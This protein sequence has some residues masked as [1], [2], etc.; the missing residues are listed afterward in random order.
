MANLFNNNILKD[1]LKDFEIP[2]FDEKLAI[3]KQWQETYKKGTLQ[4]M[5]ES[6]V[7]QSYN[8]DILGKILWYTKFP[9][10][11]YTRQPQPKTEVTGQK[12]DFWLGFYYQDS[13]KKDKTLAVIEVKDAKTDINKS[14]KREGNLSPIQ[15]GFK[16]KPQYS[17]CRWVIVSNFF[18]TK[19]FVD[20]MIDYEHWTLDTLLDETDDY[21]QFRKFYYLLCSDNLIKETG[22]SKTEELLSAV[23]I[24]EEQI[25]K[26]FY[27]EYKGLRATL[28]QDLKKNNSEVNIEILIAKAQKIIDRMVFIHFCEDNWL[29]P[30]N[31]TKAYVE[32]AKEFD[33]EP[34]ELL[35]RVFKGIDK[36][37]DKLGIPA[38]WYNGGLFAQDDILDELKVSDTICQKFIDLG[39]YDFAE[40]LS[41]NILGHIFEQSIS[42]LE[43]L[44]EE[45]VEGDKE[46]VSKRKKDGIFYTPEYIVDYIVTNSL[47]KYLEEKFDECSKN[48]K[49]EFKLYQAYQKILQNVKVLDPAC[50]SGAF[51]VKVFDFLLE[52]NIRVMKILSGGDTGM[53]DINSMSKEIL[54]NNIFGVDLNAE[55]VEITKL[56]L[57]LKTAQKGKKLATLDNNV[58]CGNSLIDD[59]EVAGDKAF[60]WNIEFKGIIADGGF[61]VI[62]GNPPY[63]IFIDKELDGYY[64]EK[65]P[66]TNYKINLYIL[67]IERM[68]Q[69][70]KKWIV[71]FI[72][73]KSLLFNTYYESIR[74]FMIL[75]SEI[76]EIFTLSEKVFADAE[77]WW[78]LLIKF[79]IKQNVSIKN[80]IQLYSATTFEEFS[81]WKAI[82]NK[83]E[84]GFFLDN[85][86]KEISIVS[87]KSESIIKKVLDFDSMKDFYWFKNGLNPG[88]IKHILISDKKNIATHKPIIWWRDIHRYGIVWSWNYI[89]YDEKIGESIS[90]DDIKTKEIFAFFW[91]TRYNWFI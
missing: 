62:V 40:D 56:S 36:W 77:I 26:E 43:E 38:P 72:I 27:K 28:I 14:Q 19:L 74:E 81:W 3:I 12:P 89:N 45:Y 4:K 63:W 42:D 29:L 31:K 64:R 87:D 5:T 86:N 17:N 76:K 85:H 90:I 48:N 83:K 84:Q 37:S 21:F 34:W 33:F 30:Q 11:P 51:L 80:I 39:R 20:T 7:E 91:F 50:G 10:I 70:F 47:G 41:V 49:N 79:E 46:T 44:R 52:E 22:K 60:N 75:N 59:P 82:Q 88:N 32:R 18:D 35:Q 2:A 67:F 53:F 78:S 65:F 57:W 54:Q 66:L 9:T 23:R 55:S 6:E 61:D 73:P 68:F 69:I 24:Q 16:Y 13:E 25:T 71:Q 58:K 1:T 15:Q 8:E